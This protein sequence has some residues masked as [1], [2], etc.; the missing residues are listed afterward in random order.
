[1]LSKGWNPGRSSVSAGGVWIH[2][3]C[4]LQDTFSTKFVAA[5]TKVS[6]TILSLRISGLAALL[7]MQVSQTVTQ[8]S[9]IPTWLLGLP[10]NRDKICVFRFE[11]EYPKSHLHMLVQRLSR[12]SNSVPRA[13]PLHVIV[14][15]FLYLYHERKWL[16]IAEL[17]RVRDVRH[18][19]CR[20][21]Q[22]PRG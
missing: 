2:N 17:C 16:G 15:D 21:L 9:I 6:S 18:H 13:V 22:R 1:M 19:R 10:Y 11:T 3:L 20:S 4:L 12:A 5:A 8:Q 14:A 7:C